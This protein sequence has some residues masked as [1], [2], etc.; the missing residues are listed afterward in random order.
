MEEGHWLLLGYAIG[1]ATV[2]ILVLTHD[3]AKSRNTRND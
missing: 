3:R 2:F 1:A